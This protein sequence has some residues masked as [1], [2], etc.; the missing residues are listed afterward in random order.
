M[1]KQQ[2]AIWNKSKLGKIFGREKAPPKK[3]V[4]LG[5]ANQKKMNN[6]S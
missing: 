1:I 5:G 2:E 3:G 4:K 6:Q